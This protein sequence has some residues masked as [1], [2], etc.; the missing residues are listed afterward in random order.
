MNLSNSG[1]WASGRSAEDWRSV[2]TLARLL[3]RLRWAAVVLFGTLTLGHIVGGAQKDQDTLKANTVVADKYEIQ[4][5]NGKT[6]AMFYRS[7]SGDA[8]LVFLDDKEHLRLAIG[9]LSGGRPGITMF[10][11]NNKQKLSLAILPDGDA[12]GLVLFDD[13][14]N[15]S[16]NLSV[17]KDSGPQLAMGSADKGRITMGLS[18]DGEPSVLLCSKGDKPRMNLQLVDG[19]PSIRFYDANQVIRTSWGLKA[20]GSPSFSLSD[21]Q[22]RVRL[23]I[24]TGVAGQPFIRIDDPDNKTSKLLFEKNP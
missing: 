9:L 7:D 21:D 1:T 4:G 16:I 2:R 20:D 22:S 14:G 19:A 8:R 23:M 17:I 24:S 18:K 5:P 6:A 10:D 13:Q 3:F 11:Q 12:P 15:P